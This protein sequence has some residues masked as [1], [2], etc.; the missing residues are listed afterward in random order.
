MYKIRAIQSKG[1]IS[2]FTI[3]VCFLI[4]FLNFY[5]LLNLNSKLNKL[6]ERY[7]QILSNQNLSYISKKSEHKDFYNEINDI[8]YKKGEGIF[9]EK[10]SLNKKIILIQGRANSIDQ[11]NIFKKNIGEEFLLRKTTKQDAQYSFELEKRYE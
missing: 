11:I 5:Y 10:F 4:V 7:V 9:I 3:V 1:H 2:I 8:M 6:K